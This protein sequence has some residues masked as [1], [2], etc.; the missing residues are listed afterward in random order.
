MRGIYP[1]IEPYDGGLLEVGD[2][3][4]VWWEVPIPVC[5]IG[6]RPTG[7]PGRTR[8]CHSCLATGPTRAPRT[9]H[10]AWLEDGVLLRDASLLTGIPGALV[11]GGWT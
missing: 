5:D 10:A 11:T 2:A 7:A 6:P 4:L 8:T 3:Q 1:P 9:G